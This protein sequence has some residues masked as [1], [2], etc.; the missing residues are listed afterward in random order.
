[1][2]LRAVPKPD[3]TTGTRK[4]GDREVTLSADQFTQLPGAIAHL[5]TY[6]MPSEDTFDEADYL[7]ARDLDKIV[8]ELINKHETLFSHLVNVKLIC[9]WKAKGG[10]SKGK[11]ILGKT[12]TASG[13]VG[14]FSACDYL[15]LLSAD[16]LREGRANRRQIEACLFRE[17]L[18]IQWN[19]DE[20]KIQVVSPDCS[21]Y[22]E[23]LR[24]YGQW[25]TELEKAG[26]AF[27]QLN[28]MMKVEG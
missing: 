10:I 17:M 19:A 28:L 23:E 13:L 25:T 8:N 11:K 18:S 16:F 21:F 1:M 22:V 5:N 9:L 20:G 27:E 4:A 24:E 26:K 2:T 3:D 15:I 7:P 14:Y 12:V 6:P